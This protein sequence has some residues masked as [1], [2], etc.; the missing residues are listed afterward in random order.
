MARFPC[1]AVVL[2]TALSLSGMLARRR[3][4]HCLSSGGQLHSVGSEC[5]IVNAGNDFGVSRVLTAPPPF[6]DRSSLQVRC[7]ISVR[8][9]A[10]PA[11]YCEAPQRPPEH[12]VDPGAQAHQAQLAQQVAPQAQHRQQQLLQVRR[13]CVHMGDFALTQVSRV[14]D[15]PVL[16]WSC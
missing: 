5:I 6:L 7:V 13:L 8:A 12:Q 3:S 1:V 16:I 15:K 2:L 10:C 11:S 9:V 4:G 14:T